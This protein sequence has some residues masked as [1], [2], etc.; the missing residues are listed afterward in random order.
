MLYKWYVSQCINSLYIEC[1]NATFFEQRHGVYNLS[2]NGFPFGLPNRDALPPL[3]RLSVNCWDS[4]SSKIE[5]K[6]KEILELNKSET[7]F[8]ASL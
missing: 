5:V 4:S 3:R 2:N 7:N 1:I 8:E 6:E